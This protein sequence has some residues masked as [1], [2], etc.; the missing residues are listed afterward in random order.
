MGVASAVALLRDRLSGLM[1]GSG[2]D[3]VPAGA[4]GLRVSGFLGSGWTGGQAGW[5]IAAMLAKTAAIAT[6]QGQDSGILSRRRR[7]LW[8]SRA[9]TWRNR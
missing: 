5:G 9:G 7:A 8:T 6:A 2:Y 4:A 1:D 3:V